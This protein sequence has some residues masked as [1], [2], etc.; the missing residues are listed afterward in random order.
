MP[1]IS[2]IT[3]VMTAPMDESNTSKSYQISS[4]T[5]EQ[6]QT[7]SR[8]MHVRKS[9]SKSSHSRSSSSSSSRP[10]VPKSALPSHRGPGSLASNQSGAITPI[11]S[12]H[13]TPEPSVV[14]VSQAYGLSLNDQRSLQQSSTTNVMYDQ[15]SLH[16]Q[17]NVGMDPNVAAS[18]I[19]HA[20]AVE[21][22]AT[23]RV[24][25]IQRE[26]SQYTQ[27][28]E[29]QALQHV[30]GIETQAQNAVEAADLHAKGVEVRANQL[31]EQMR[32]AHKR[33]LSEVQTV[34]NQA[35]QNSQQQL[36]SMMAEIVF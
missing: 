29:Q 32:D 26:T 1:Q 10:P 18:A 4:S 30:Q 28:V 35:Y 33:E 8:A 11:G 12:R 34:A 5:S 9:N 14:G 2:E 19:A 22:Q 17:V 27:Q 6:V 16:Q 24:D 31:L 15:R 21:S 7:H 3:D 13:G 25:E 20:Y 36:Q 23:Q